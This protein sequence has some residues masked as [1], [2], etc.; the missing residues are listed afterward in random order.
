MTATT[1][2]FAAL[3]VEDLIRLIFDCVHRLVVHHTLWY[4]EVR[5]Q[6]GEEAAYRVIDEVWRQSFAV[7]MQRLAKN[8]GVELQNGYPKGLFD[9]SREKLL[10][11]LDAVAL[12]WLANDGIWFQAVEFSQGMNDAKRCND[13]CWAH[14]SPFE[15]RSI[16]SWLRLPA[17]PG[18]DGLKQ[19]LRYRL[20]GRVNRQSFTEE[21]PTSFIFQMNECRVQRA[22]QRKGLADY[23]CKSVGLVEYPYFA[24]TIDPRI[25]TTCIGCP[26]DSHPPEWFCAWRFELMPPDR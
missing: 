17:E 24:R 23:P 18:L 15:A 5:H 11:L 8:L 16:L 25:R 26:P 20:Y 2:D 19:A 6:L 21:S 10:S 4:G 12:N 1:D 3:P 9:L 14:F 13:S 7:Q 22:R